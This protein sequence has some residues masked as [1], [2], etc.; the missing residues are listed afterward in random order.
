MGGELNISRDRHPAGGPRVHRS[1]GGGIL[2]LGAK[3]AVS[4]AIFDPAGFCDPG[5]F[6]CDFTR[7]HPKAVGDWRCGP[8][9]VLD[10]G[11][12]KR[13]VEWL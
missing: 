7:F 9:A 12:L 1:L 3:A 5:R 6:F 13:P 10:E 8:R 2:L 11:G 4:A